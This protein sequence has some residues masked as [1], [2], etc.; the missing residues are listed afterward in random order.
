MASSLRSSSSTTSS[1]TTTVNCSLQLLSNI[2]SMMTVKLDYTNYMV[3]RHH[4]KVI[5]EAYSL[6]NFI[7]DSCEALDPFVKDSSRRFTTK[8]NPD[9]IN[10]KNR[11]QDLF[12]FINSTISPSILALTVGQKFARQ[13][14]NIFEKRFAFVSRS[15]IMNLRNE[16]LSIKKGI[17]TINAF[18]QGG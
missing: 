9:F 16:V 6:I 1:S 4:I 14:W 18:F 13:V 10:W 17:E 7:D 11:G 8:A 15:H 2:A 5:L 3:G 12:T